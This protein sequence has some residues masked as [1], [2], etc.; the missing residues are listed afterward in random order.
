LLKKGKI[1]LFY[2]PYDGP[3]LGAPARLLSL[4][5][6]LHV[7]GFEVAIVDAAIEPNWLNS[8]LC[9]LRDAL[10]LGISTLAGPM[11]KIVTR[12]SLVTGRPLREQ[13]ESAC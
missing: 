10:C 8:V 5:A 3:P 12:K 11:E 6:P 1:V 4:A 9:E 7:A 13:G 2:L